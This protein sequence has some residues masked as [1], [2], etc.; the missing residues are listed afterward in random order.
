M[1]TAYYL[2]E[3]MHAARQAV[4]QLD[5]AVSEAQS[6]REAASKLREEAHRAMGRLEK[7][8]QGLH[9]YGACTWGCMDIFRSVA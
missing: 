2:R 8:A 9:V 7:V 6:F 3:E 5:C 1:G 4:K